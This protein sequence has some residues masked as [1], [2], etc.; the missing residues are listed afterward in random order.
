[1]V[2]ANE[3]NLRTG[4]GTEYEV[5][6]TLKQGDSLDIQGRS[7]I[8]D[9]IQVIPTNLETLGWVSG[10]P[11]LVQINVDLTPI[12]VAVIPPTP[13]PIT[14]PTPSVPLVTSP[15]ILREPQPNASQY[16]NRIELEW[17]W[18]GT[19]GPNDYFQVEIR[20]RYLKIA[21]IID[22]SW[23]TIDTAW[24]KDKFYR[25]DYVDVKYDRE[26]TW[27]II[28]VRYKSPEIPLEEKGWA[29]PYPDIQ[30]WDPPAIEKVERVSDPSEMRVLFVEETDGPPPPGGTDPPICPRC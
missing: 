24:V 5:V 15:P 4:P 26:Y 25:H 19:L 21:N 14:T 9:W 17:D 1:M 7:P 8:N 28:V 3:L 13:T 29:I 30:V 27:R 16:R 20:N 18:S 2:V 12:L 22:E 10:A 6:R 23:P 11:N